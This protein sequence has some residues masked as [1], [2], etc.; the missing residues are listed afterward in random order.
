MFN[1]VAC[2]LVL[3][4]LSDSS[5]LPAH[6]PCHPQTG[7][8]LVRRKMRQWVAVVAEETQ[9]LLGLMHEENN[10]RTFVGAFTATPTMGPQMPH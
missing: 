10:H 5:Y 8:G 2:G 3:L 4:A 6:V 1:R 9:Q 7:D